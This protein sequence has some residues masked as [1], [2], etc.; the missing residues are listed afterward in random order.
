MN[1]EDIVNISQ[2]VGVV[3]I[4][5]NVKFLLD[6]HVQVRWARVVPHVYHIVIQEFAENRSVILQAI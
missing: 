2:Y 3:A 4:Y 1:D 5:I 6:K